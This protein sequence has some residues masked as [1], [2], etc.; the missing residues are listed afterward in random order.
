MG[1]TQSTKTQ[2]SITVQTHS[3]F[4]TYNNIPSTEKHTINVE[5]LY[6]NIIAYNGKH[7]VPAESLSELMASRLPRH[8]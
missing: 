6:T 7:T 8:T 3:N 5:N 4:T 1:K 2:N